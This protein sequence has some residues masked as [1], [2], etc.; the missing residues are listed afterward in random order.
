[1][2][3]LIARKGS[4]T[5][6]R[7]VACGLDDGGYVISEIT[8]SGYARLASPTG[9]GRHAAL[10]DQFHEGQRVRILTRNGAL[11]GVTAVRSTHLWRRRSTPE[12][13]V[14]VDDLWLDVGARSR[15][16]VAA[17]GIRILDP[18]ER[19]WPPWQFADAVAGPNAAGRAGCAAVATAAQG[20]P[21]HGETV[22]VISVQHSYGDAGLAAV[23]ARLGRVDSL[24]LVGSERVHPDSTT[25]V[26][27][28]NLPATPRSGAALGMTVRSTFPGTLVEVVRTGDVAQ[29]MT[30]VARASGLAAAPAP[31][32]LRGVPTAPPF[33]SAKDS[34]STVADLIGHLTDIYG[35]SGHEGDVRRFV[36]SA[37]PAAWA[38]RGPAVDSA[39]N[40]FVAAGPPRDTV[41]FIAHMDELGFHI[42]RIE[43]DGRVVLTALGGF[44]NSLWEGEPA[45]LHFDGHPAASGC[46][47]GD[48]PLRG[49]FIPRTAATVTAKEPDTLS[50][51][52]G[53]DSAALAGC[54]VHPGMAV[55]S[56]KRATRVGPTR[57][58]ARS[59][60]DRA[61]VTAFLLALRDIDPAKLDHTVIFDFSTR[62]ET[63]LYGA[64]ALASFLG[65]TVKR[66][67]AVDTFVSS[68]SPLE[69]RRFAYAPIGA[70]AVERA[71][72]NSSVTPAADV[73][74]V[75]LIAESAHIPL[76]IGTTNGGNDGSELVRYGAINAPLSWPLRY[77]HSP[78]E[79]VD[80]SDIHALA[81]LVAAVATAPVH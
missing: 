35:P 60:D 17:M 30:A 46:A 73:E 6:R 38:H 68:D 55:T 24:V 49:V 27:Q 2:G 4:G 20:T 19:E 74:R 76:Q 48:P 61:G 37:L 3:N 22:W 42:I 29:L 10:W 58:S 51:W 21:Q 23:L 32:P 9:R 34:L 11:P 36:Q 54:G 67:H 8:D 75:R 39:G 71:M 50:A 52:F 41:V 63:G 5:P 14:T 12:A 44:Y 45:L 43:H 13:P 81:L 59:I 56:F 77:S 78:A 66:V 16:E 40:L 31:V 57:F 65:P 1:M 72:D 25:P 15:A 62:E 33:E 7:V 80:L 79:L 69:S 53:V 47:L 28:T 70:G 18:V 26:T 64:H